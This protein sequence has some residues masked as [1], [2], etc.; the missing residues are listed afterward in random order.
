MKPIIEWQKTYF[1]CSSTTLQ[2]EETEIWG[3]GRNRE[4]KGGGEKNDEWLASMLANVTKGF[5]LQKELED[6]Q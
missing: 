3:I 6:V 5:V 1:K 4:E 2:D